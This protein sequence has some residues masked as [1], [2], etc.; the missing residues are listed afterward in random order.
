VVMKDTSSVYRNFTR[1]ASRERDLEE[2][3]VGFDQYHQEQCVYKSSR[4]RRVYVNRDAEGLQGCL[5]CYLFLTDTTQ[6]TWHH[7]RRFNIFFFFYPS[8]GELAFVP[9]PDSQGWDEPHKNVIVEKLLC[10]AK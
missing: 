4:S 10:E 3:V 1:T 5:F 7:S 6:S 2:M 8:D 9:D